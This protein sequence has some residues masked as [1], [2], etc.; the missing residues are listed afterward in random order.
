MTTLHVLDRKSRPA[1]RQRNTSDLKQLDLP[2]SNAPPHRLITIIAMDIIHGCR[3][4][5]TLVDLK[6]AVAI[7]LRHVVRFDLPDF[8]RLK[9]FADLSATNALYVR[10]P[11]EWHR[12]ETRPLVDNRDSL[13]SRVRH[14]L[15]EREDGNVLLMVAKT[16]QQRHVAAH[17]NFLLSELHRSDWRIDLAN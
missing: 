15:V 12:V 11:V 10:A 8:S 14:E 1:V 4:H 9:F 16:E 13:P 17:L 6:P 2:L 3:L 5:E 7:D